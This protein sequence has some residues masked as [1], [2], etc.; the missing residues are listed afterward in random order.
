MKAKLIVGVLIVLLLISLAA[1]G[2]FFFGD[3]ER[4]NREISGEGSGEGPEAGFSSPAAK[5]APGTSPPASPDA[6]SKAAGSQ[7]ASEATSPPA[8]KNP[9]LQSSLSTLA[10]IHAGGDLSSIEDY[11]ADRGITL[12]DD[13]VKVVVEASVSP[14]EASRVI[15]AS[16]GDIQVMHGNLLQAAVPVE[17][18]DLLASFAAVDYIREPEQPSLHAVTEGVSDIGA[19]IW[20]DD[21]HDGSGVKLAIVDLGF[22]GYDQRI[23]E[24]ELPS[25]VVTRSFRTDGDITGGGENHGTACAELAYDVAPGAQVY[26]VNFSTDVELGNAIDYLISEDIDV[27]SASWGFYGAFRGDGQGPVNDLVQEAKSS[28]IFWANAA[29]NAASSHWSGSFVDSDSDDYLEYAPG[30]ETNSFNLAAGSRVDI[31][32]TWDRWPVTGEDYDIYLVW[33]GNPN[34][35]VAAG[36]SWQAGTQSPS[37][38]IHY[39]VPPGHGGTYWVVIHNYS[40]AGD[41]DFQLF[42]L[43]YDLEHQV[44]AFSLGGQPTDSNAVMTVGAVPS[45]AAILE[46]FS[47]QG[48]T[49]DG[50]TKPDIVAPDRTSTVT[51]GPQGFWGTSAAAPHVAAAG[52]LVKGAYPLLSP[53]ETQAQLENRATDLGD[54]GKDNLFGSGKLN[55][56]APPD[57]LPPEIVTVQPGGVFNATEAAISVYYEDRGSG[58]D[59]GS[60]DVTLDGVSLSGCTVEADLATCPAAGL[61]QGAHTIGGSVADIAGNVSTINGAFEVSCGKPV[62]SLSSAE[63]F[64]ASYGDYTAGLLSVTF[65]ICNEGQYG[66]YSS[67]FVGSD[68]TSGVILAS[69][70]PASAG[71]IAGGGC[72]ETTLQYIIPPEVAVFRSFLYMTTSDPCEITYDYPGPHIPS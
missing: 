48:P 13:K 17:S 27:V 55:M 40:A 67:E 9:K 71:D 69:V 32:L 54:T 6:E 11:A 10:S 30:D 15:T 2:A 63:S 20:H 59:T 61:A 21:G 28:G 50:R 8:G 16:G 34:G 3:S 24:G 26:L 68:N 14:E 56:G 18:L 43:P 70:T 52:A 66:S 23:A 29:G 5:A 65:T 31:Y 38:A 22:D 64:W 53:A 57:L 44:A 39:T 12:E 46:S 47:S 35:A 4:Q 41:A 51:Y 19:D 60:V 42:V 33:E 36:D 62:L 45:G 1:A 25:D 7:Q 58:I 49:L 37:E 72:G